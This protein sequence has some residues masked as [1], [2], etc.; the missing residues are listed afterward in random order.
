MNLS[1]SRKT[2]GGGDNSWLGSRH[3]VANARSVT[4]T[5]SAFTGPTVPSGTPLSV[6]ANGSAVPYVAGTGTLAF[7][8]GSQDISGGDS[9][10]PALDHGRVIVA[11]LPVA[12]TAPA[13]GQFVFV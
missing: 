9:T 1:I 10:V 3:G 12:F 6:A 13:N 8:I 5:A 11:K 2:Y 7:V 4:L